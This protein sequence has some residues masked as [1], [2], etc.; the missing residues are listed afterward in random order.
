MLEIR[1]E[2]MRGDTFY[3]SIE[4]DELDSDLSAAYFTVKHSRYDE[5][6]VFQK[7]LSDGISKVSDTEYLIRVAPEDTEDID[8]GQYDYDVEVTV[9]GDKET[10]AIGVLDIFQDVTW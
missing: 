8:A 5:N 2:M 7:T 4:F 3:L 1:F 10:V 9:N 6:V